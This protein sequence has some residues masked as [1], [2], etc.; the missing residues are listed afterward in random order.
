MTPDTTSSGWLTHA[1]VR[2][3]MLF[4]FGLL[5]VLVVFNTIAHFAVQSQVKDARLRTNLSYEARNELEQLLV[6]A[7]NQ[8]TGLRGYR[9]AGEERFLVPF[10]D[11]EAAFA[12]HLN[13][14]RL[15]LRDNPQQSAQLDLIEAT[16][17]EW[18]NDIARPLI[19]LGLGPENSD[20]TVELI[21]RG[22]LI[23]DR[24]RGLLAEMQAQ[25]R[26]LLT[27]RAQALQRTEQIAD[28]AFIGL[29]IL[30]ALIIA[31]IM[32]ALGV[33]MADPPKTVVIYTR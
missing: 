8:Q 18:R 24:L 31:V 6:Q 25:E 23:F 3:K 19:A 30:S 20:R 9:L 7:L 1:P 4:A 10:R 5:L 33:W 11:G 16:L 26:A 17:T 21:D 27:A 13:K 28:A 29:L 2:L 15:L 12:V 14:A 22:K 32:V